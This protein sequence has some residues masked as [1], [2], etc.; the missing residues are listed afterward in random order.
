MS[1]ITKHPTAE[2]K[3][4]ENTAQ[5]PDAKAAAPEKKAPF[6]PIEAAETV[7]KGKFTLRTPIRDGEKEYTYLK[8]D[9]N[10]LSAWELAKAID[11]GSSGRNDA[12]NMSD[13]QALALFAAAAAKC[14]EGGLDATDIRERMGASDGVA[15][16]R[17]ASIFF[18]GSSLAGSLRFTKE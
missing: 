14:T 8:Y 3:K 16:I 1:E 4:G 15:A 11:A 17:V 12:F 10:A 6:N 13:A 2:E 5:N 18:N 9:F 7:S